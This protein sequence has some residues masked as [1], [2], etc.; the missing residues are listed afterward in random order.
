M[1]VNRLELAETIVHDVECQDAG[2]EKVEEVIS[3]GG[4]GVAIGVHKMGLPD[5]PGAVPERSF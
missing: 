5:K 4:T 3:T 1:V 2:R